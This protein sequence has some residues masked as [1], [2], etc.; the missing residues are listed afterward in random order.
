MNGCMDGGRDGW[1]ERWIINR[2]D[3]SMA[4]E[5]S[6]HT[7]TPPSCLTVRYGGD[8]CQPITDVCPPRMTCSAEEDNSDD[9][10][11]GK[12]L[13]RRCRCDRKSTLTEDRRFCISKEEKILGQP[14]QSSDTCQHLSS[15]N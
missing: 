7:E 6:F 3:G 13:L 5:V 1:M 12:H 9:Q 15:W 4:K 11:T 2:M 10:P 14:C 8:E